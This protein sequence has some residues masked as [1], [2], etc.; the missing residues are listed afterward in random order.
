M[1]VPAANVQ[2]GAVPHCAGR[3]MAAMDGKA[4]QGIAN[5]RRVHSIRSVVLGAIQAPGAKWVPMQVRRPAALPHVHIASVNLAHFW[6]D[7]A[8]VVV[9]TAA[10]GR[11]REG[12][13]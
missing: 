5:E 8:I 1:R 13:Q 6:R 7:E 4:I 11:G 9:Q 12:S 2:G 10:R 3:E